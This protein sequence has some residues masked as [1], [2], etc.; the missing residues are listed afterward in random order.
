M[1]SRYLCN[2][3]YNFEKV[4]RASMACGPMVK[5]AIAQVSLCLM[6]RISISKFGI[7]IA[8]KAKKVYGFVDGSEKKPAADKT[9]EVKEWEKRLNQAFML[10][11]GS[12][13]KAL[14]YNMMSCSTAVEMWTKIQTL[15]GDSS[16]D[17][18]QDTWKKFYSFRINEQEP[19]AGQLEQ[20]QCIDDSEAK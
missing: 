11:F 13:E 5:W 7:V 14:H 6:A 18:K 20:F 15:Y 8:I 17:A 4:N 2:P 10:L 3:E 9:A 12:V 1:K 16:V 19:V